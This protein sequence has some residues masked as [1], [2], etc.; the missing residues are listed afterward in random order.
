MTDDG[1]N[2]G[3]PS[4][5]PRMKEVSMA[6]PLCKEATGKRADGQAGWESGGLEGCSREAG[7][8][9]LGEAGVHSPP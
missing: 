3:G 7:G 8:A 2:A 4:V 5:A 9:H 6:E 1:W